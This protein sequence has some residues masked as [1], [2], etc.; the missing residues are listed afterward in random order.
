MSVIFFCFDAPHPHRPPAAISLASFLTFVQKDT[1]SLSGISVT[2]SVSVFFSLQ[3]VGSIIG[4]VSTVC[5]SPYLSSFPAL[6][7]LVLCYVLFL[8]WCFVV[9][10]FSSCFV[11]LGLVLLLVLFVL[12]VLP[13]VYVGPGMSYEGPGMS[14]V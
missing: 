6:L 1:W 12:S 11:S 8:V 13:L 3:E 10:Y 2:N 14:R 4:K 5:F 7:D 9:P